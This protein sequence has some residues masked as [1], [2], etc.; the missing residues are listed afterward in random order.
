MYRIKNIFR[1]YC[2]PTLLLALIFLLTML[3]GCGQTTE[4]TKDKPAEGAGDKQAAVS[5]Q[6][7]P[8]GG[9]VFGEAGSDGICLSLTAGACG[10][11]DS[12]EL[13]VGSADGA[14]EMPHAK[15]LGEAYSVE[16]EPTRLEEAATLVY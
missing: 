4:N 10:G 3:C 16:V 14:P 1:R 6:T 2:L 8:D 11:M 12:I 15:P 13:H 7:D 5:K 9:I